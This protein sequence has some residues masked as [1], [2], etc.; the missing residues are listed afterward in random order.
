MTRKSTSR[1]SAQAHRQAALLR[2]TTGIVS[3]HTEDDIYR[4]MVGGL[5]DEA[6]GY[7]FLGA[8]ILE[9]DTGDRDVCSA[10]Q[11]VPFALSQVCGV[12]VRR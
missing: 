7:S 1:R 10:V 4:A 12:P 9:A 11:R 6:L 5:H 2:L 3:A 8:F